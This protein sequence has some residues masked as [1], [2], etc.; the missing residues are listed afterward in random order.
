M[1][2]KPNRE[3]ASTADKQ[4]NGMPTLP[5]SSQIRS[6]VLSALARYWPAGSNP[7]STLPLR[8]IQPQPDISL[9]LRLQQV[10]VPHW[11]ADAAVEGQLLVPREAIPAHTQTSGDTW[12]S[13]DWLLAA[14][15]L[16]EGWHERLWEYEHGPIH[17]YSL[18]LSRWDQRAWQHAWVNRI[19]L[20][21][22]QWAIQRDG[23]A[24]EQRLGALPTAEI[25]MT[26]DVD[27]LRKTVPIRIKQT[28]FNLFNA[29][30]ALRRGQFANAGK[31]LYRAN[32][33][34]FG[35]EDWW[36][37]DRLMDLEQQAGITATYHFYADPRSKTLKRWFLDP[38][39]SIQELAQSGLLHRLKQLGYDIGLHPGFDTWQSADQIAAARNQVQQAADCTV[40]HVRQHWLRFSWRET[41]SA[42]SSAGLKQDTTLMFNDR[43]GYRTSSA[44]AWQPWNP[45]A[46]AAHLLT[47]LPTVL[48]DS[49]FYDYHSLSAEQRQQSIQHWIGEC[50]AV[51]GQ[52]A[53]LWHPHTLSQD[54][55]WSQGFIDTIAKFGENPV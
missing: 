29:V 40:A 20:F 41:W 50:Q 15:L 52:V 43:P 47:A 12:R 4:Q 8:V 18:C 19:G 51:R 35:Q 25:R 23:P 30:R 3:A 9:P 11:A 7:I 17:S 38:S 44:L 16:L 28:A 42:Q 37:F 2:T 27:A 10:A 1:L 45:T 24:A 5:Q 46:N 22:R 36:V 49:H 32:R 26:H 6:H 48:M 54:Y 33:F 55:G 21:L 31:R 13:V 39:Y 53:V 14:F 34:L